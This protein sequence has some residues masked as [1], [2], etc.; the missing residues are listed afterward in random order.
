MTPQQSALLLSQGW[1]LQSENP[2]E[3][4][5]I[6]SGEIAYSF[7]AKVLLDKL[8]HSAQTPSSMCEPAAAPERVAHCDQKTPP[9]VRS[10]VPTCWSLYR[11]PGFRDANK[12]I[13]EHLTQL[14]AQNLSQAQVAAAM[15][16][17]LREFE[18]LGATDTA[19]REILGNFLDNRFN[20]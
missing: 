17:K 7:V 8:L 4:R 14:L 16:L 6:E 5:H 20:H 1:T 10:A 3:L 12:A 15:V 13:T 2:L 11:G 19:T 9:S 18:H